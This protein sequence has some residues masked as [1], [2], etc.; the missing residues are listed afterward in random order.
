MYSQPT[1][2]YP[3][4]TSRV[5]EPMPGAGNPIVM[6]GPYPGPSGSSRN[7][8]GS[9]GR[10]C[11]TVLF[12]SAPLN[13]CLWL[14][15]PLTLVGFLFRLIIGFIIDI[16]AAMFWGASTLISKTWNV[17]PSIGW[18]IFVVLISPLLIICGILAA[19][20]ICRSLPDYQFL[21][22]S[23]MEWYS[24]IEMFPREIRKCCV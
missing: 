8:A 21:R 23:K 3:T 17:Y 14:V 24:G 16:L 9:D 15:L 13:V 5:I 6:T 11:S 19:P 18:K 2:A 4:S 1:P 7:A 22:Q 12:K 10:Q 20:C